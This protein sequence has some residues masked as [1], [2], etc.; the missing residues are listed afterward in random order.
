MAR[1]LGPRHKQSRRE[2]VNLT[3]KAS[4]SLERR[5]DVPPGGHKRGRRESD[6]ALRLRA[7]QRAKREY[8]LLERGFRRLFNEAL[9]LP[10]ITG[11]NLLILL[12][13]RLDNVVYR[14]G[15]ARTRPM[16]RQLVTH[17]HVLVNNERMTIP[18]YQV[19]VGD[20]VTVRERARQIPVVQ[21]EMASG[22][23][24]PPWLE[25]TDLTGRVI[26]LP[27]RENIDPDIREDMIV[28]FYS[29]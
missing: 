14:L 8:G 21:E 17:G 3:G 9:G 11:H 7:K 10:G 6:Y 28:E 13:R 5:L 23:P 25:R 27:R 29:R 16:A 19:R 12:E 26:E 1:Y 24:V 18:S 20:T 2:G 22:R 15:L 4:E